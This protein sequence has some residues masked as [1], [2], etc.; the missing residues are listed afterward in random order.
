MDYDKGTRTDIIILATLVS[1]MAVAWKLADKVLYSFFG[2]KKSPKIEVVASPENLKGNIF[3]VDKKNPQTG[4]L[5]KDTVFMLSLKASDDF[6]E[7]VTPL[8]KDG[9][10]QVQ[11]TV[12][13]KP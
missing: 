11:Q 10:V 5:E 4:H 3:V 1:V 12:A 8:I 2:S 6:R 13:L 7:A 9:K